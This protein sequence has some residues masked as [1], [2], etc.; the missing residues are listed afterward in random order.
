MGVSAGAFNLIFSGRKISIIC[1]RDLIVSS[2]SILLMNG[3]NILRKHYM[4]EQ[5]LLK[6]I[7]KERYELELMSIELKRMIGLVH[8]DKEH[9]TSN[10]MLNRYNEKTLKIK[11]D[12]QNLK[13]ELQRLDL[14]YLNE[15]LYN[16]TIKN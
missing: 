12:I 3:N 16:L 7:A 6:M 10:F 14:E 5:N 11:I 15:K 1:A 13:M 9:P 8:W 4:D 2:L